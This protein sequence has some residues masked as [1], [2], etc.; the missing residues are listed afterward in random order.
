MVDGSMILLVLDLEH[1]QEY[2][3]QR[4][5]RGKAT[6]RNGRSRK[7]QQLRS[8]LSNSNRLLRTFRDRSD[9][10]IVQVRSSSSTPEGGLPAECLESLG[11]SSSSRGSTNHHLL[12]HASSGNSTAATTTASVVGTACAET[13][14]QNP[15]VV[16]GFPVAKLRTFLRC[17]TAEVC[18]VV[19]H[20][21]A[22]EP[23]ILARLLT[24]PSH[25]HKRV[26]VV[27]SDACA[28]S[29]RSL[30]EH[31]PE[32][33][34]RDTASLVHE[35]RRKGHLTTTVQK[36]ASP[37]SIPDSSSRPPRPTN[38]KKR[39]FRPPGGIYQPH[40]DTAS[41]SAQDPSTPHR[42]SARVVVGMTQQQ[43]SPTSVLHPPQRVLSPEDEMIQKSSPT[44][45]LYPT[46]DAYDSQNPS[47]QQTMLLCPPRQ[48][49]RE[50]RDTTSANHGP[51]KSVSEI[52]LT[53]SHDMEQQ[54][55]ET[56]REKET[57]VAVTKDESAAVD[58][59]GRMR[60]TTENSSPGT[61]KLHSNHADSRSDDVHFLDT[62]DA[63]D[64][65][66]R[67]T[68][69]RIEPCT[70][71]LCHWVQSIQYWSTSLSSS[72]VSTRCDAS[73]GVILRSAL[74]ASLQEM[75][76]ANEALR[77]L[78]LSTSVDGLLLVD[79]ERRSHALRHPT[80]SMLAIGLPA[81]LCGAQ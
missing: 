63:V 48:L 67:P 41:S 47:Q 11:W 64:A 21:A 14:L 27:V 40:Q 50:F 69:R 19:G 17:S 38:K 5:S 52:V 49:D 16:G 35:L 42:T 18:V 61:N 45:T 13:I 31:L 58:D 65:G 39:S 7:Q 4:S 34:V 37:R 15:S 12:T 33:T 74:F 76:R 1:I 55:T 22:A 81:L 70:W 32:A 44:S 10:E 59:D 43:Q 77:V 29:V 62:L 51:E 2:Q 3:R 60:S 24:T 66:Q 72:A 53:C 8:I 56:V 26:V 9:C 71:E 57:L 25:H 46:T 54:T 78:F 68:L 20:L 80:T 30:T 23:H 73:S 36:D 28:S 6:C 79:T 75:V